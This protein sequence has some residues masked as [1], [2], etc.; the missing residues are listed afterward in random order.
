MVYE[1]A[2]VKFMQMCGLDVERVRAGYHDDLGDVRGPDTGG[3]VLDCK[4]HAQLSLAQWMDHNNTKGDKAALIVKRRQA[5]V[6]KSYVI[7]ELG[8]FVKHVLQT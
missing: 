6:D 2:V 8:T 3:W 5:N 4:N 1:R 7:M